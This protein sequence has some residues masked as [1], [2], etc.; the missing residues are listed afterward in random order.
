MAGLFT[1]LAQAHVF[2][3]VFLDFNCNKEVFGNNLQTIVQGFNV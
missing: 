1:Q 2:L 3:L